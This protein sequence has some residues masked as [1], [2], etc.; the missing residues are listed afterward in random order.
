MRS[1]R[2]RT[3]LVAMSAVAAL[4]I[5]ISAVGVSLLRSSLLDEV[6]RSVLSRA[7]D[8]TEANEFSSVLV[9]G[10]ATDGLAAVIDETGEMV[11]FSGERREPGV[12]ELLGPFG[13][14]EA[15][16]LDEIRSVDLPAGTVESGTTSARAVVLETP[17]LDDEEFPEE[18][19]I[20]VASSTAAADRTVDDAV[21]TLAVAGP[22]LVA[23]VGVLVWLLT[24]RALRGVEVL[25]A[26]VAAIPADAPDRRVERPAGASELHLL[27]DTLN[28]LLERV[29]ASVGAQQRFVADASHELRSPIASLRAQL[30]VAA[31]TDAPVPDGLRQDVVRLQGLVD[32][33]LV[34]SRPQ[35]AV[36]SL[37]GNLLDLDEIV[38]AAVRD[39]RV[40]D[41]RRL[42]LHLPPV[43]VRGRS[44][45]LERVV[46]NLVTNAV[47]HADLDVVVTIGADAA[48]VWLA[49]DDDGPG[50]APED[51]DRI[52]DRFVRLD[53]ARERDRGGSGLGLAI[54]AEVVQR[55]GGTIEVAASPQGGARFAVALPPARQAS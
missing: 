55:H 36:G 33:L 21:R 53:H 49:V 31:Q 7:E 37:P 47:R 24:G 9:V 19:L 2:V 44:S 28:D 23:L 17:D 42:T 38:R 13:G 1:L 12:D 52:F 27:A 54:V 40:P 5:V 16:E 41:D 46:V 45:E 35:D 34:L 6:D 22:L 26:E 29:A 43:E 25:R 20:Y 51:R 48:R 50:I 30:E 8:L 3:A 4:L 14:T 32:D 15:L 10:F 39:V 11:V 18:Y